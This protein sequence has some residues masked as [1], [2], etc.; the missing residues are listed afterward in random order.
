[1]HIRPIRTAEDHAVALARVEALWGAAEGTPESDELEVL[2]DL[3]EHYKERAFPIRPLDPIAYLKAHMA[4]TG[5]TQ[6]DLGRLLGSQSRAS[7][8]LSHR[9]PLTVGMIRRL[10]AEWHLPAEALVAPC[11]PAA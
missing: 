5:R 8:I 4:E 9:R 3:I 7:E 6:A 1:V 10:C 11:R 2:V